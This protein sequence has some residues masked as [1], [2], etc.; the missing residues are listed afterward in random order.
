V[1]LRA[2]AIWCLILVLAV[3]NGGARDAWLVP[4]LGETLGS[5]VSSITLSALVFLTTF[6]TITWI[7]PASVGQAWRVGVAWLVLTLAFEFLAGHYGFR[8]TWS[9]LLVDYNLGRGRIWILVLLT[10]LLSPPWT[11]RLRHLV[12]L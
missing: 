1:I 12:G 2:L 6:A 4:Q 5:A 11:A 7:R 9:E 8:K 10:T 3:L